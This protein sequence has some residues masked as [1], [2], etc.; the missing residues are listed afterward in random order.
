M[1]RAR[2]GPELIAFNDVSVAF[3]GVRPLDG[4]TAALTAPICGLVGPNGA[5]KTTLL[6]VISGF[7]RPLRGSIM[8][9]QTP[10]SSQGPAARARAGIRRMF[11]HE[12]L[13]LDMTLAANLQVAADHLGG[14]NADI[15]AAL[16]FT[17]LE[18]RRDWLGQDLN[19]TDR[20]LAE[21]ARVIIGS[22]RLIL[23]DEPGAGLSGP[24]ADRLCDLILALPGK[25][26]AQVLV[27]DHDMDLIRCLC[28]ETLVLDFG[29]C[30][31]LGET[32]DVLNS[33]AVRTAYLGAA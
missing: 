33:P 3:G 14:T 26:G 10:L 30:I 27:I 18:H 16:A 21:I 25:T 32:N 29:K 2:A 11:Q 5:G 7:V 22:A 1:V 4:L 19:L 17:G 15:E 8:L 28:H 23:L 20:R 9:D 31:A 24:E 12:T 13:V 6:N